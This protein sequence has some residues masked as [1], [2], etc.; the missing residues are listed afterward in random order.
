MP[1]VDNTYQQERVTQLFETK[2][3][4]IPLTI[5]DNG[6]FDMILSNNTLD[7]DGD[8][9]EA[10]NW[11][12]PLPERISIN[13]NHSDD[14]ADIVGSGRPFIDH[15]GNL[16]VKGTFAS[17]EKAQ[18][19]R[20]LVTEGHLSS[21][22]VECL[23]Y[24]DG[25]REL[26]GGGFVK[27]PSNPE[28]RVLASK[29]FKKDHMNIEDEDFESRL[30]AIIERRMDEY[31]K[32]FEAREQNERTVDER[33]VKVLVNDSAKGYAEAAPTTDGLYQL[34][35]KGLGK[36][37][38]PFGLPK[39]ELRQA[40]EVTKRGGNYI[41]EDKS[42][43][44]GIVTK[45]TDG[46]GNPFTS[47][48]SLLVAQQA[49]GIVPEY[50]EARLMDHLPVVAISAPS[51]QFIQHNFASDSGGPD[52]VAEGQTKAQWN[53]A[54]QKVVVTS[55]KI[56]GFYDESTESRSDYAQWSGYLV[57]TLFQKIM[58]KENAAILYGTVSSGLGIQG[59][60]TLSG[61]LTHAAG[62]DP[63]GSTNLDSLEL[64]INAMRITSGVYATPSICIMHPSTWSY[65]RRLKDT[66]G[67]YIT[68][69][70]LHEGVTSVWG[71]PV[72][73]TTAANVGD[74]FLVD[75]AKFG[76]V[77]VHEGI[78][79]HMGYNG[80]GLINNI[81]TTVAEERINVANVIPS[82]IQYVTG[83]G[84]A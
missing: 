44:S 34:G 74:A 41:I 1:L 32:S 23:R 25:M 42:F 82:A 24:K 80:D 58:V 4:N 21:V 9:L 78:Q 36:D 64:A 53:P 57:N 7:R 12:Q 77:L 55:Q 20:Q 11:I 75:R 15:Q 59:W 38:Y 49:P 70:P 29:S 46:S 62:S 63:S 69:D 2:Q 28:A 26:T 66:Q 35:A 51:Y 8:R 16:R 14:V 40:Y 84:H 47:V 18:N 48:D 13:A 6:E 22:S 61:I 31:Q 43:A 45:G 76:S 27:L 72:I 39:N 30:D 52:F 79:T 68:G 81:L 56:A 10:K 83:L 37:L 60:S 19:I 54:S 5:N 50:F 65:T 3:V 33:I 67:R 17:T 73:T 71:V